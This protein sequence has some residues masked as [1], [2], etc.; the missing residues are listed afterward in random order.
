MMV[1]E[2]IKIKEKKEKT[3]VYKLEDGKPLGAY[4]WKLVKN[5]LV[6]TIREKYRKEKPEQATDPIDLANIGGSVGSFSFNPA[7]ELLEILE[8]ENPD[9]ET[10]IRLHYYVGMSYREI[11]ESSENDGLTKYKTEGSCKTHT[12]H[13]MTRLREIANQQGVFTKKDKKEKEK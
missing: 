9:Y 2:T 4:F 7:F 1:K 10:L 8:K 11:A 5:K 3:A 13:A 12:F 6:D